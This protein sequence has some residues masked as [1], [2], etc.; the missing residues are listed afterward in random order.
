MFMNFYGF[1][2]HSRK[3]N[4]AVFIITKLKIKL[5]DLMELS[6]NYIKN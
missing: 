6:L 2:T 1:F 4:S 5:C 3:L